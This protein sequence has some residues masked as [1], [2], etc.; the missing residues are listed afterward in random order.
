M[1]KPRAAPVRWEDTGPRQSQALDGRMVV[2][3]SAFDGKW[4]LLIRAQS[5]CDGQAE[6]L[7]LSKHRNRKSAKTV[8]GREARRLGLV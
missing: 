5:S 8:G 2:T 3:F 1:V 6:V 4:L 7:L